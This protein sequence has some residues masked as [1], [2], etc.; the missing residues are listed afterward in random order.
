MANPSAA[1][2]PSS[3]G[4]LIVYYT[5]PTVGIVYTNAGGAQVSTATAGINDYTPAST[6]PTDRAILYTNPLGATSTSYT[7]AIPSTPSVISSSWTSPATTPQLTTK[8]DIST[9][10]KSEASSASSVASHGS[11]SSNDRL[12]NGTVAGIVIAVAVGIALLTSLATFLVMRHKRNSGSNKDYGE[13]NGRG[14]FGADSVN[15]RSQGSEPKRPL[16]TEISKTTGSFESHLPQSAD[17]KTIQNNAKT[18]LDQIELHVEN[19]YQGVAQSSTRPVEADITTFNSPYLSHP[20]AE[21]LTESRKAVPL[22]KHALTH[23]ITDSISLIANP[24]ST[25]LPDE[26][27]LLPSTVKAANTSVSAKPGKTVEK[28]DFITS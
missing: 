10:A 12:P 3:Q 2:S 13:P 14:V 15:Q 11:T 16:V 24:Y 7:S 28:S 1:S 20:L 9:T 27:V 5:N 19:F 23:V 22:I 17:D 6:N 4:P 21:L 8:H 18:M 25:L 26:F